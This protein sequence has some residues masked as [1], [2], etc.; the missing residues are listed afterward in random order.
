AGGRLERWDPSDPL[1]WC[2]NDG[3]RL[4]D[5]F[6]AFAAAIDHTPLSSCAF[7]RI[8]QVSMKA[9]KRPMRTMV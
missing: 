8:E 7:E 1:R 2:D 5:H 3:F 6:P 4:L 9:R